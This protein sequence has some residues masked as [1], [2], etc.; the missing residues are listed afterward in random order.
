M[1]QI[2]AQSTKEFILY[3]Y[4]KLKREMGLPTKEIWD[5]EVYKDKDFIIL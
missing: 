1:S 2:L 5:L 4:R 3:I